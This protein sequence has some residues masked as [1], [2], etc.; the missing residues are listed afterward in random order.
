MEILITIVIGFVVGLVARFLLPGKDA[1]GFIVTTVVGIAGAVLATYVGQ[2]LGWYAPG[3]GA[4]FIA[5]VLGAMVLL[6][7]LRV[8]RG[9][10]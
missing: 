5:S 7:G 6:V 3:E 10:S 8:L 9:R 2:S 1:A 4:R